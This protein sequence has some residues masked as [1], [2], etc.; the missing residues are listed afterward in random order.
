[1][2]GR[3]QSI[4]RKLTTI[5]M[6]TSCTVLLLTFLT[7]TAYEYDSYYKDIVVYAS[8][9][10][11]ITA[12]NSSGAVAFL[13][14]E[15]ANLVLSALQ[16]EK[17]IDQAVIYDNK[18]DIFND[19]NIYA[20]YPETEPVEAF[21]Q[22]PGPIGDYFTS[23]H[24]IVNKQIL[25]AGVP[26]GTLYLRMSLK[27]INQR[28]YSYAG[29][30]L[31]V[32]VCAI[33][34]VLLL[35][36]I[37]QRSISEPILSLAHT[38]RAVSE[39]NDYTVRAEKLSEDEIG[40]LTDAFN[41]MLTQIHERDEALLES[42][43]HFR[44]LA[45][46][47]PQMVWTA[48]PNGNM[49]YFNRRWSE[50]TAMPFEKSKGWGWGRVLHPDD[51]QHSLDHWTE[52]LATERNF[53]IEYRLQRASDGTYRWHLGRA[54]PIRNLKGEV[55]HW[56]GT[57]TDI[58]DQ[59]LIQMELEKNRERLNLALKSSGVGTWDWKVRE[60]E[61]TWDQYMPPLHGCNQEEAPRS[62]EDFY[63]RIHPKDREQ[64]R[65]AFQAA[66]Y[67][68]GRLEAE[69]RVDW[70]NGESHYLV[71]RGKVYRDESGNPLRMAGVSWDITPR[72]VAEELLAQHTK[73][74]ARS[75]AE[76]EKFAYVASHDLQE[77]LRGI[78]G[79]LQLLKQRYDNR[80]DGT[81]NEFIRHAVEGGNRMQT[82]INDLLAYSRVGTHRKPFEPVD[83][84]I[85]LDRALENLKM[86]IDENQAI[87]H[88]EPLPV[89]V[90]EGTQMIQLFQ[91][92][93]GNAI[94]FRRDET[95][96]I[97]IRAKQKDNEWE[98]QLE[99]N[100][101]G[102]ESQFYD[103]VFVIF[104]RLHTRNHYPG[105][106][107]GLAICKKIVEGHDGRIWIESRPGKGS[108]FYFTLP[109]RRIQSS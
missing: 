42:V 39:N 11:S 31:L 26:H 72:R 75:N 60:D 81:A 43:Q 102:M 104:Q 74:L 80:L 1:M 93:I 69:F 55:V 21:P 100:G 53:I 87:I 20:K 98:F 50:Y 84:N 51:R 89:V 78:V 107:I 6:V 30:V 105:T 71:S 44:E 90:V 82:L 10:A 17:Y 22:S 32:L 29:I 88:R 35:S 28:L 68:T 12:D 59:K 24:I 40:L 38:A 4:Q 92:L 19:G 83:C 85:L 65:S 13:S 67:E 2:I 27:G 99:D 47:M 15:E 8:T 103:R 109:A 61:L 54:V 52:C 94:K 36:Q 34:I 62:Q 33:L 23:T 86:L 63:Q 49:D 108:T 73:E 5:I 57:C 101:I 18:G 9:V 70:P 25:Q 91:N 96:E 76:L 58:H 66:L 14:P 106:G 77:P 16:A 37:L 3:T 79:C 41:H 64:V 7:F 46:A 95:P 45:D 56:Y 97:F 48:Q